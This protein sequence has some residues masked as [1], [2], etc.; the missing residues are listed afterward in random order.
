MTSNS[1]LWLGCAKVDITPN[2]PMVMG[3][4]GNRLDKSSGTHDP[5]FA[6]AIYLYDG[7]QSALIVVCDLVAVGDDLTEL[8][9]TDL[10]HKLDVAKANIM[11]TATHTHAGPA[12]VRNMLDP[13][14]TSL[15]TEMVSKAGANAKANKQQVSLKLLQANVE[16]VSQNRRDP[17]GPLD[18]NL[19]LLVAANS[20]GQ[21]V[22]TIVS[23]SCHPTIMEYDN[24]HFS[25]DFP[26][27][28]ISL[29]EKNFGGIGVF[30]QG[31]CGD[32]NPTWN[33]HTW[34]NVELNGNIVGSAAL[35]AAYKSKALGTDRYGVNLSW[36]IDTPQKEIAGSVIEVEEIKVKSEFITL[37]R[38]RPEDV[39][40]DKDE[41]ADLENK[42]RLDSSLKNKKIHQPRL[43]FLKAKRYGWTHPNPRYQAGSDNLEIQAIRLSKDL[44]FLGLP[45]EYLVEVG[46]KIRSESPFKNTIIIG[47]AN[48]YFDYFPLQKDFKEHGYEVG[49]SI[50]GEG[51]TEKVMKVAIDLL[52]NLS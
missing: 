33:A 35:A 47:Y 41:I 13:D 17:N 50:Y 36:G 30:I 18:E 39:E 8:L 38:Q 37:V 21:A 32:I 22:S 19:D 24:L 45:G 15:L 44:V 11:I 48:G 12:A 5:L 3:G 46:E 27:V 10:S 23:F 6:R 26:G 51:S 4:Y 29:I 52:H 49:R 7:K 9:R 1:A 40:E 14:Y 2:K 25:A 43:A 42:L 28:A 16:G 20:S 34:E 31:M